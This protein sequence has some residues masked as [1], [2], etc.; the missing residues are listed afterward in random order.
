MIDVLVV[1]DSAFMRKIIGDILKNDTAISVVDTASSGKEAIEKITFL[2]PDVVTMDVEMPGMDGITAVKEIMEKCPLPI[3]MV[4]AHTKKGAE[5]TI[6]ALEAGALDFIQ[7]PGGTIS[8]NMDEIAQ[9]LINKVKIAK[10][11]N[12]PGAIES[13][14]GAE[15]ISFKK[16]GKNLIIIAASTGGPRAITDILSGVPKDFP[17]PVI[18]IQHMPEGFT[19]VF[20]ARLNTLCSI[21]VREATD[22]DRIRNGEALVAPGG[23]HLEF[24]NGMKINLSKKPP[25]HGVR[26]AADITMNSAV[27]KFHGNI[28]GVILSGMGK[29]GSIGVRNIK[30]NGGIIITQDEDSSVVYGMPK[31]AI[32]TGT[33]DYILPPEEIVLKISELLN[34]V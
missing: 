31:S 15:D 19:K 18:V 7:K 20:A 5:K 10:D 17:Y 12:I 6:R 2:T 4:S 14:K 21:K 33:V 24:N 9:D 23:F 27:N 13:R 1:D 8:L 30:K 34:Y 11:A 16:E 28:I 3:I 26:P 29:D 32:K 22:G 25:L